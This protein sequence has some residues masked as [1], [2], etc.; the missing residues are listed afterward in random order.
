MHRL[1]VLAATLIVSLTTNA[2][3]RFLANAPEAKQVAEGIVASIAAG[4]FTG[5][6]KEMRPLS[7][8]PPAEVEVFEA[9]FNSQVDNLLRRFGSSSGY[10]LIREETLGT[11]LIRYQFLVRHQKAPLRWMFVFYKAEKGW[12]LTD[13]KFDGNAST[14]FSG[15]V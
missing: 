15:G 3:S 7:V 4:N 13:F 10:E 12:V 1:L 11:S 9:Q 5:A 2:Q 14:F 8:I 6:W